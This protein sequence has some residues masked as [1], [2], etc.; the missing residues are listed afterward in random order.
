MTRYSM[1]SPDPGGCGEVSAALKGFSK[2][3]V[4]GFDRPFDKC[5]LLGVE[6]FK[7]R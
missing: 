5:D 4:S 1:F 7:A 6:C 2:R 3:K